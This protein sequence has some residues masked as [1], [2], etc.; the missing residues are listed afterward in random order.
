MKNSLRPPFG[1]VI[2]SWDIEKGCQFSCR[3][4][5][6]ILHVQY[7]HIKAVSNY[8]ANTVGKLEWDTDPNYF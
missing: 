1:A 2:W 4:A 6:F 5:F 8:R 3:E 7:I